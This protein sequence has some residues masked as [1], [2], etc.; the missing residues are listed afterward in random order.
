LQPHFLAYARGTSLR[1]YRG[2]LVIGHTGGL[3]G[4]VSRVMLVPEEQ[5]GVVVLTN[6][7]SDEARDAL[8]YRLLDLGLQAPP[9]DWLAAFKRSADVDAAK[10]KAAEQAQQE[11]RAGDSKPSL[12]LPRY[13]GRYRDAWYGDVALD[14]SEGKLVLRFSHTPSLVADLVHWQ[15]DTFVA[16]WRDRTVPDA[17]VSFALRPDASIEQI[18]MRAV[19]PDADFSYDYQ[20]LLLI[21]L[22]SPTVA[23]R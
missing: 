18:R 10:E 5:L 13:A 6:Q 23:P 12:P 15:Y 22:A 20:D 17:F 1:D 3:R 16:R 11:A 21:P 14:E 2:R 9:T 4:M 7:E 19:S 8:A